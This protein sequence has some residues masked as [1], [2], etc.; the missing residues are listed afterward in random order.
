MTARG[1]LVD[2]LRETTRERPSLETKV[3]RFLLMDASLGERV[4]GGEILQRG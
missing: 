2:T 4:D 1:G 3:P